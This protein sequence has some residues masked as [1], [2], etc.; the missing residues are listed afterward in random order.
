LKY[1]LFKNIPGNQNNKIKL[2]KL[3]DSNIKPNGLL[4][5]GQ[6]GI[7]KFAFA[8]DI[9]RYLNVYTSEN[10]QKT[11]GLVNQFVKPYVN[12]VFPIPNKQSDDDG[13]KKNIP[14][15][16]L[17]LIKTQI[18]KK[19]ENPFHPIYFKE[20]TN[21]SIDII[22]DLKKDL[23]I[24][25]NENGTNVIIIDYAEQMSIEAQNSLLKILEEPP[26]STL[27]II[28]VEDK[29]QIVSTILSRCWVFD[30]NPLMEE[31][32]FSILT[33]N[34]QIE[35][36]KAN[37]VIPFAHG[38]YVSAI[39]LLQLKNIDLSDLLTNFFRF[40]IT[41]KYFTAFNYL[42]QIYENVN[43]KLDFVI[44]LLKIWLNDAEK[45]MLN[46]DQ[47]TFSNLNE[48]YSKMNSSQTK[49][50][51]Y[52]VQQN[53]DKYFSYTKTNINSKILFMNLIF[54]ISTISNR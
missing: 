44:Y 4:F 37:S 42:S 9:A 24:T 3:L 20:K 34:F 35:P 40:A 46:F 51:F 10:P 29:N 11:I 33:N 22:R 36:E 21:I 25:R 48:T 27:F 7:G 16:I 19:S 13:D 14:E 26:E 41:K 8:I 54:E 18:T 30:F 2:Q 28:L 17:K 45:N 49:Y 12:Y 38:S 52:L 50:N 6:Y 47:Y 5:S 32:V 31:E 15:N 39:D 53:L 23:S 43:E 1:E